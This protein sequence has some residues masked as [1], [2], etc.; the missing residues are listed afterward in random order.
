MPGNFLQTMKK[1]H[2]KCAYNFFTFGAS[3]LKLLGHAEGKDAVL[4]GNENTKKAMKMFAAVFG[5]QSPCMR[6]FT[7]NGWPCEQ[8]TT[9]R[10]TPRLLNFS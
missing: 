8:H 3:Y 10:K 6:T 9:S 5:R 1:L 7:K 4:E 2:E